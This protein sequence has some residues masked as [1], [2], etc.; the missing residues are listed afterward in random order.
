MFLDIADKQMKAIILTAL[1]AGMLEVDIAYL[2]FDHI[3]FETGLVN[4]PRR[5]TEIARQFV[6]WP[7]AIEAINAWRAV[8][9]VAA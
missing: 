8:R 3:D 6:L 1:A 9:P 4:Y 7:E 2:T 5:K